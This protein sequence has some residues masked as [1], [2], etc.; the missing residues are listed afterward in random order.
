MKNDN[1]QVDISAINQHYSVLFERF[2]IS[3]RIENIQCPDAPA[4]RLRQDG[5]MQIITLN[6]TKIPAS[7][8]SAHAGYHVRQLLLPRLHLET[9]RLILR[10][11]SSADAADCFGFLSNEWDAY[12]DCSRAFPAMDKAFQERTELFGQRETQYMIELKESGK[13]IGTVNVFTDDS[14]AVEAMEIGYSISHSHQRRGYAFEA[15]QALLSLLQD[16][17]Y[18]EMVTAGILPENAA[19]EGLLI[20]LGFRQEGLRHKAVWH[21]GLDRPVDLVYFY[22]DR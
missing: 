21:E 12:M 4:Y 2:Q 19:S 20:K 14:R 9:E 6:T 5:D 13:V 7:D 8:Y 22:R 15:L 18:L 11:Y 3:A 10:R 16:D 17:L 1:K